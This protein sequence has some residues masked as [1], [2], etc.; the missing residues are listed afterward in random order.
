MLAIQNHSILACD[1]HS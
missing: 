1:L